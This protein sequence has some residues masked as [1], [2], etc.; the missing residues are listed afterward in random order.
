MKIPL[1]HE[2]ARFY[3]IDALRSYEHMEAE[4]IDEVVRAIEKEDGDTLE[5]T[6]DQVYVLG[7]ALRYA[8]AI[9]RGRLRALRAYRTIVELCR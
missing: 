3:L 2:G 6:S 1:G 4:R 9:T 8:I 5:L 7:S